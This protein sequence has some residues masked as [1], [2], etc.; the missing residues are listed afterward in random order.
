[1]IP[2]FIHWLLNYCRKQALW[3]IKISLLQ[4]LFIVIIFTNEH[5]F[6]VE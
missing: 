1:M 5:N 6:D 3:P 4:V 2:G